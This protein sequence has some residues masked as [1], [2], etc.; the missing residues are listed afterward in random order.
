MEATIGSLRKSSTS[1]LL[2]PSP[3]SGNP[4]YWR[5]DFKNQNADQEMKTAEKVT[6][7]RRIGWWRKNT[8][9]RVR[10]DVCEAVGVCIE[11]D[12]DEARRCFGNGG[13]SSV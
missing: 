10:L 2:P 3:F 8:R 5:T 13:S 6:G 1:A 4:I 12:G 7:L 11:A 9:G